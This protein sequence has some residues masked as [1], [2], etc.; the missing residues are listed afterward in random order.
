MIKIGDYNILK[1]SREVDFGVYLDDGN[2]GILLPKR[3]VPPGTKV[4]DELNVF[5]YHD[6][7]DRII[8]T[9]LKPKGK[10]GDIVKLKAVSVTPQGAF[11]DWGLMKDLFVPK[12]K[13]MVQ[14]YPGEEYLVKI[15]V[16]ERT[17]RAAATEKIEP[18]LN[19]DELTVKDLESVHLTVYRK[20][21]IGYVVIIN[22]LHTGILHFS[23]VYRDIKPGDAFQGYIKKIYPDNKID[24][25]AGKPGYQRVSDELQKILDLLAQNNGYLPYNDKSDPEE[26]YSFFGMSKKTFK[27]S[28]GSLYKQRRIVFTKTG[29]K[30]ADE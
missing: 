18:Y 12:S 29:I 14:M 27:M 23:E 20:T 5:L 24:V 19:N 15:Y 17:G 21:E 25:V 13:Q 22:H 3:F 11:L 9:T 1:V 16:D 28:T 10:V 8:A 4:D 30:L 2:E 26:I 7:E 6:S